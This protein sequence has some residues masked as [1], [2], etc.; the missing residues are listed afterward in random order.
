M[1][2]RIL[3][4]PPPVST[5]TTTGQKPKNT[6]PNVLPPSLLLHLH[7]LLLHITNLPAFFP[8]QILL[9][10]YRVHLY[11]LRRRQ[12]SHFSWL[13]IRTTIK[14]TPQ[15]YSLAEVVGVVID[16]EAQGVLTGR[17]LFGRKEE[18]RRWRR[19]GTKKRGRGFLI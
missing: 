7:H 4:P 3:F 5:P 11:I 2:S 9:E 6:K 13:A 14:S 18:E 12:P 10:C 19:R 16:T 15:P 17:V 8:Q 1:L